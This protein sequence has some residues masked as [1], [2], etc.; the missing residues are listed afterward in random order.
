[1]ILKIRNRFFEKI[2]LKKDEIVI[3]FKSNR[4]VIWRG[5]G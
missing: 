5:R 2:M 1:M 4:I 3:R